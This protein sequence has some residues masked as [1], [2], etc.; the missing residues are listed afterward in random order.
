MQDRAELARIDH[1]AKFGDLGMEAA[2][3]T[4]AESDAGLFAGL[5]GRR[6][7]RAS[8]RKWFL[9]KNML[10]LL[11]GGNRLRGVNGIRGNQYHGINIGI[12]NDV[13]EGLAQIKL[14]F[15]SKGSGV[16]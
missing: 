16:I 3:V 14:M 1:F 9:T 4:D 12:G 13:L 6:C 10:A 15:F 11:R 5:N 8:Q 7:V 2:V